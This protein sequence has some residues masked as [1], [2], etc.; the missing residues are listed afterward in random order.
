MEIPAAS[1][2]PAERK[3]SVGGFTGLRLYYII[4]SVYYDSAGARVY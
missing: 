1:T 4:T 2:E 3:A